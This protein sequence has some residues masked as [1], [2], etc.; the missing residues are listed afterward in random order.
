[1]RVCF[2]RSGGHVRAHAERGGVGKESRGKG[3][4]TDRRKMRGEERQM[5][6]ERRKGVEGGKRRSRGKYQ[7]R[8]TRRFSGWGNQAQVQKNQIRENHFGTF[9][10]VILQA[11]SKTYAFGYA[12]RQ[13]GSAWQEWFWHFCE[14]HVSGPVKTYAFGCALWPGGSALKE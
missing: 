14:S 12:F 3:P 1:M 11:L 10:K 9:S 2:F 6:A 4:G 8:L 5:E 7:I 13:C